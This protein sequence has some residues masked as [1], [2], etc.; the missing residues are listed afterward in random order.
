MNRRMEIMTKNQSNQPNNH[1]HPGG[2]KHINKSYNI[3]RPEFWEA[4][5]E[6]RDLE[7]QNPNLRNLPY[8]QELRQNFRERADREEREPRI[9]VARAISMVREPPVELDPVKEIPTHVDA[10]TRSF[11]EGMML[12]GPIRLRYVPDTR[13]KPL[14]WKTFRYDEESPSYIRFVRSPA[15]FGSLPAFDR[16]VITPKGTYVRKLWNYFI[17]RYDPLITATYLGNNRWAVINLQTDE[18]LHH[19]PAQGLLPFR[20]WYDPDYPLHTPEFK[21][22]MKQ[23]RRN[24]RKI[25]NLGWSYPMQKAA[26]TPTHSV[27]RVPEPD[28]HQQAEKNNFWGR[29]E[30]GKR[31]KPA[32]IRIKRLRL[33]KRKS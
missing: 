12:E 16:Q 31:G 19:G 26:A 21:K 18:L 6:M 8:F 15:Q 27:W 25:A 11:L 10:T 20:Y 9:S 29:F 14:P 5:L 4:E 3:E 17:L 24:L 22:K 2:R 1:P 7:F 30:R 33:K 23:A 13:P 28:I 32:K